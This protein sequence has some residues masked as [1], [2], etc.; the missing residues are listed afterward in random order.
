MKTTT[1]FFTLAFMMS[2]AVPSRAANEAGLPGEFLNAGVG[3]RPLGMGRAFTAVADDIDAL[4]WN[5]AGLASYRS[6][7][8][9][10]MHAPFKI[11][12]AHQYVAYSQPIYALGA[13]GIGIANVSSGDVDRVDTNN[14]IIGSFNYRETGYLASYAHRLQERFDVGGTLKMAEN[15]LA[16]TTKRG[17]GADAGA[18]YRMGPRLQFGL[19][20]RNLI[21]PSYSF[22]T[23]KEEF[24]R[25][26]RGGVAAKF[27]NRHLTTSLDLEKTV[28]LSQNPR[29]HLGAEGFII[30]NI[31]LRAGVDQTEIA[32]GVG[33]RWRSLQFDYAAAF[34]EIGM[35][36]RFSLKVF[37]GGYEVDVK[38]SP[39][40][41]SPVGLKNK[42]TFKIRTSSRQRVVK[43][44]LSVRDARGDV[45]RSFQG[46]NAPPDIIEWDG[47]DSH[48]KIVEPGQYSYRMIISDASNHSESTPARSLKVLA[49][50]P[51][52]IEAR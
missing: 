7:Q 24:P 44:I 4:Y 1:C 50:S 33:I 46:F 11:D 31:F 13:L 14:S 20:A 30:D 43:W 5:P 18:L 39:Q 2:A 17:F 48:E 51:F 37:F 34:Q 45:I 41:F 29:W 35:V 28:G 10:F 47:K 26:L 32:S 9:S 3:A 42:V 16:G 15:G 49:P 38:A 40:V 52:E 12:G 27:F 36:S 23:E 8:V 22:D 19:M 6:S 25:I 21:A